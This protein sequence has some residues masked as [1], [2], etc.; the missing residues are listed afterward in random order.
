VVFA[1]YAENGSTEKES[2][3]ING[4]WTDIPSEIVEKQRFQSDLFWNK[5]RQNDWQQIGIP[6]WLDGNRLFWIDPADS[7][8]SIKLF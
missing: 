2:F 7:V 1:S 3:R 8:K 4:K 5:A 6:S